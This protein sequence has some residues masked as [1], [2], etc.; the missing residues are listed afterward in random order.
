M[1][2]T[3][4]LRHFR[5]STTTS[6]PQILSL[7]T[8]HLPQN[9][10]HLIPLRSYAFNSAEEAAAER[11]RIKR[12]RRIEPPL[13]ALRRDYPSQQGGGNNFNNAPKG[14]PL[15]DST[16]SLTGP[17]LNL[18]NRVQ[19]LIR[20]GDLDSAS[21]VA[22]HAVF[23]NVRPTV[24]TCNA[25]IAAMYRGGR[26]T[27]SKNLFQYFFNQSN[28]IPNIVSY[29]N[30]ILSHFG[31]GDV[32]EAI[33]VYHQIL[34][35]APFVPSAFTYRHL[36]KG[37]VDAGRNNEAV[38]FLREMLAKGQGADSL[39][40]NNLISGFLELGNLDKANEFFEELQER[41][42]VY[43]G[44][45]S[46]TF[47][48]W[49]FKQGREKEAMEAY[50]YLMNKQFKMV[51]ATC[52]VLLEVL[53]RH[54][55]ENE[56]WDLFDSMLDNHTP[57][58][59]QA[60]NSDTFN[61]MVNE[62]FRLGKVSEAMEVFKKVGK[63]AK[64]RPFAM[65][66]AGFNN[67]I[68]RMCEVEKFEEAEG[69]FVQLQSK[70]LSPD[71]TTY[72]TF[73]DTYIENGKVDETLEKYRMMVVAGLRVIPA[74]ANK[75]FSFLI[76]KGKVEECVP[77]LMKTCEREPKPDVTTFE[78][79]IRGLCGVGE[80]EACSYVVTQMMTFGV[81]VTLALK[82]FLLH[83]FEKE[84]RLDVIER[85]VNARFPFYSPPQPPAASQSQMPGPV[86]A[87]RVPLQPSQTAGQASIFLSSQIPTHVPNAGPQIPWHSSVTSQVPTQASA[88][89]THMSWQA[90]ASSQMPGQS[91]VGTSQMPMQASFTAQA[92][93][94][95][96]GTWQES[97]SSQMTGQ[98]SAAASQGPW[99]TSSTAPAPSAPQ[100]QWQ[101]P[102]SP[103]M[104]G[105]ASVS[106]HS[107]RQAPGASQ[108]PRQTSSSQQAS[109][110]SRMPWQTRSSQQAPGSTQMPWQT[111]SSQQA[112]GAS[113]MSWQ[114][115]SSQ[116]AP[117]ASQMP[118]QT[119]S[120][121]QAPGAS[122]M[123]WQT[124]SSQQAPGASQIPWQISSQQASG[125]SQVPWQ[126]SYSQQAPGAS[127]M[128]WQ[129]SFSPEIPEQ[130]A[131]PSQ[132]PEQLV[133]HQMRK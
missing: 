7:N 126:T 108:M 102:V 112:P 76:E 30:L 57:P 130:E 97:V 110:A 64:S 54:G 50:K 18:H 56:A 3:L 36:T 1:Y 39:V 61:I 113:Q 73:I 93:G 77:I 26:Y 38:D 37:L 99:Q 106:P 62:C 127:Q 63:A 91:S 60:V 117:G 32:E 51:P 133:T 65:D 116:Q 86:P 28:I 95:Y 74:Y 41:C 87:W 119:S 89:T 123:P 90:S 118:W 100:M 24:F 45:V 10:N 53:V 11:R 59:F 81:G 52:N 5:R 79:V 103:Q 42:L 27:D 14:P 80:L 12:L 111:S 35:V 101:A 131:A 16:S 105:H 84:G 85:I 107:S 68:A 58:T 55:K 22:R 23:S 75:W 2:R 104:P 43:D 31:N 67:M 34:E 46:A 9:P 78:I 20:A 114:T 94:A 82:E 120:S 49:F 125:A 6:T 19:S 21:S 25:I 4:L 17:R 71:V 129:T 13:S 83:V 29:N 115:S 15:P 72:R 40:Y 8:N 66:V 70:S 48:D 122:Q 109:G 121:Q 132:M 96:Q 47:M 33:K 88:G 98:V 44:V 124:S 128:P 69:Y 92:P